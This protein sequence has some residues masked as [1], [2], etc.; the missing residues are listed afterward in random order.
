MSVWNTSVLLVSMFSQEP[1]EVLWPRFMEDKTEAQVETTSPASH[2]QWQSQDTTQAWPGSQAQCQN[3]E[4]LELFGSITSFFHAWFYL[5]PHNPN[6][7]KQLS[8]FAFMMRMDNVLFY[9]CTT[10]P[11]YHAKVWT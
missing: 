5:Q 3:G 1:G 10:P 6:A 9:C 2:N 8:V 4:V 11:L 7:I